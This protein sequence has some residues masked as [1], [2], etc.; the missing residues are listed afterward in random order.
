MYKYFSTILLIVIISHE[1]Q[2][3]IINIEDRRVALGDSVTF[4]GFGDLGLNLYRNDKQTT[5]AKA[6]LQLEYK[7]QKHFALLLS[8]YNLIHTEGATNVL[9][10]G[11][12]HLR[13][14]YDL[15]KHWVY[16][17][18]SQ[19][20]YNERTRILF[21]G[22][23]GTG[24]RIKIKHGKTQRYYIGLSY[25]FESN[26]FKDNTLRQEDHRLS[27][28]LSYNIA[29]S[30]KSRLVHT[31]YLQPRLNDWQNIRVSSEASLLFNISKHLIF[32]STFNTAYDS[33]PRLPASVPDWIYTFTNGLR[34]EF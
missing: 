31:T 28:Y 8:G 3:Q 12:V 18:F 27:G 9:N 6:S 24:I 34:F 30:N 22:L 2:A 29:F 32:R 33:D 15:S 17:A 26:Q 7:H 5:T 25:L 1:I 10:D 14:N 21:R 13:Y 23:I 20:Q 19:G 4:K 16:E 11:F